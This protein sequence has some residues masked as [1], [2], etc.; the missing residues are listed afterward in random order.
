M[1]DEK[2]DALELQESPVLEGV[3]EQ[4]EEGAEKAVD[5]RDEILGKLG[6]Y[7]IQSPDDIDSLVQELQTF[8]RGYGESRNEIGELRRELQ[9]YREETRANRR[10][11]QPPPQ[12]DYEEYDEYGEPQQRRGNPM[13][14]EKTVEGAIEK[15][16]RRQQE[17]QM[18]TSEA[19]YQARADVESRPNWKNVQPYFDKALSRPEIQDQLR[20]GRLTME[21]LYSRL[22]EREM[23][24]RLNAFLENLPEGLPKKGSNV[25]T[26]DRQVTPPTSVEERKEKVKKAKE[27]GDVEGVIAG[28]FPDNDPIFRI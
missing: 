25:E 1:S 8:K 5:P 6:E 22:S 17:A 21:G 15:F 4:E 7:N 2:T 14:I 20:S 11:R 23:Y 10:F 28:L 27:K 3:E 13:D 19:Y 12:D 16:W 26:A 9:A 24:T 18:R